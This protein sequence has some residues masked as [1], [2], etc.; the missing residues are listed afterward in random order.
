MEQKSRRRSFKW[1]SNDDWK[2]RNI[3]WCII[4]SII[5]KIICKKRKRICN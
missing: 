2:F 1:E 4:R 5:I 3:N